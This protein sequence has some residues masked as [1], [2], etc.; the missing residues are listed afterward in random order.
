MSVM[1]DRV[2]K[3]RE[4]LVSNNIDALLV[5][6]PEN[7]R[8]MSGFTG[9]AG[10]LIVSL[11][12]AVLATDFRYIEQGSNQAPEFE[13]FRIDGGF[14]GYLNELS[15]KLSITRLGFESAHI[16]YSFYEEIAKEAAKSGLQ[17]VPTTGVVED[18]RAIK[19]EEELELIRR[20]VEITDQAF[21][22]IAGSLQVGMTEKQVAWEIEKYMREN[23]ADG[24]TFEPIVASGPNSALP[25]ARPS[26][27]EI[28]NGEPIVIDIGARVA[29]Y[30]SD[31]TRT[32]ILGDPGDKFREIYSIVLS[33]QKAATMVIREGIAGRDA[34][35]AARGYIEAAG[36]GQEFGHSLGHGVGLQA[37]ELPWVRKT[38]VEVLLD[39]MVTTIEPGIY[40][41]G[42]GGV[43]IEDMGVVRKSGV[44]IFT[45]A[46]KLNFEELT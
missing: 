31:L 3:L 10:F 16:S 25:H 30:G 24:M 22:S 5:S 34:D 23:G 2:V 15:N 4:H 7:R 14:S 1:S 13:I 11:R 8:Y 20:A 6:T 46:H 36:F 26:D 41:P 45:R 39:G 19:N 42:W 44:E 12:H 28:C 38:T 35:A 18:I 33:A 43:R 37:H 29:G 17:L 27:R 21:G 40:L 32:V 9:S